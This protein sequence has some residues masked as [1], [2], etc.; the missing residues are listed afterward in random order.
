MRR[1][2]V[3]LLPAPSREKEGEQVLRD[4]VDQVEGLPGWVGVTVERESIPQGATR[5]PLYS[6]HY[7]LESIEQ[8]MTAWNAAGEK[9]VRDPIAAD[10]GEDDAPEARDFF[11]HREES[12]YME[13]AY[14][15]AGGLFAPIVH[16]HSD[17]QA[18]SRSRGSRRNYVGLLPAAGRQNE[19][20]ALGR[21]FIKKSDQLGGF[22]GY[23]LGLEWLDAEEAGPPML[24]FEYD[25]EAVGSMPAEQRDILLDRGKPGTDPTFN[26]GGG[27]FAFV[28]HI[29]M[30]V[31]A[32]FHSDPETR[33][34]LIAEWDR[35]IPEPVS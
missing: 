22:A 8:V 7:D 18:E 13:P 31:L 32:Q 21:D 25:F 11:I 30:D 26:V 29:Q 9:G 1:N 35:R 17:L 19:A 23:G 28:F 27:L 4:F 33:D 15:L 12:G 14:T 6:F 24:I 34:A 16:L 5:R 20:V 2:Y 3:W 10:T